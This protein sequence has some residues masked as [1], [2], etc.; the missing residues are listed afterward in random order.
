VRKIVVELYGPELSERIEQT[1]FMR[2]LDAFEVL[3]VLRYDRNEFVA[4]CRITPKDPRMR[5]EECFRGDPRTAEVEVLRRG[6][7]SSIA[8][9]RRTPVEGRVGPPGPLLFGG[10]VTKPGAGYLLGPLGYRDGT[11]RFS[12]VGTDAQLRDILER[13]KE[14]RLQYRVVSL[15]DTDFVSS[16][17]DRL[18]ERQRTVLRTAHRL[19]YYEVPRKIDSRKLARAL[20]LEAATVVEHLRKAEQRLL[21]DLLAS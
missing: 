10:E 7:L 3:N 6:Q 13:A 9:V 19:G 5:A 18:T 8:L 1:V 17:L 2:R 15:G 20:G 21:D 12:F 16:P 14:R 4:I 11:L